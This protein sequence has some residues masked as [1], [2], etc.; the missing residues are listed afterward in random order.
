ME[1]KVRSRDL[2]SFRFEKVWDI[3]LNCQYIF[4]ACVYNVCSQAFFLSEH[5]SFD[6]CSDTTIP[7]KSVKESSVEHVFSCIH[8]SSGSNRWGLP[9]DM[10][11]CH[12]P[13]R[14]S[15]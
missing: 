1:V 5:F 15:S 12:F 2:K 13:P 11:R 4:L 9:A 10:L 7:S 3:F 6:Q 8:V 14:L